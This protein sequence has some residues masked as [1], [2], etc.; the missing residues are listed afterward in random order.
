M[1]IL[2]IYIDKERTDILKMG[3]LRTIKEIAYIVDEKTSVISNYYHKL[4]NP[5]GNLKYCSI[6]RI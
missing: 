3:Q 5:R 4:I 1:W 2:V 6:I